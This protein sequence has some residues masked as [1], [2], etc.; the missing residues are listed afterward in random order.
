MLAS[1]TTWRTSSRLAD[2]AVR[3][4]RLGRVVSLF[5]ADSGVRREVSELEPTP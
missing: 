5:F 3:L 2:G 1:P 4:A